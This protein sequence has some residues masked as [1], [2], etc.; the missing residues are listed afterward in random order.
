MH[1]DT[2]REGIWAVLT[3]SVAAMG[4]C[5]VL[6]LGACGGEAADSNHAREWCRVN[7][8]THYLSGCNGDLGRCSVSQC[9][10]YI[11]DMCTEDGLMSVGRGLNAADDYGLCSDYVQDMLA[12]CNPTKCVPSGF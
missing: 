8:D 6:S 11:V 12:D 4:L 5:A 2:L 9:T 1:K 10:Q 7:I 3:A